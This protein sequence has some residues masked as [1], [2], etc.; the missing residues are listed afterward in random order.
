MNTMKKFKRFTAALLTLTMGAAL[1]TGCRG[2]ETQTADTDGNG[3]YTF[4]VG[5]VVTADHSYHLGLQKFA[6]L[7]DEKTDG[8]VKVEIFPA[9]Q[10]GNEADL[11][12][13]L[14]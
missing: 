9:G 13:G 12:E 2:G 14:T 3:S 7:L 11:I 8:K 10:L 1:F 6:E 4:Q 5:H